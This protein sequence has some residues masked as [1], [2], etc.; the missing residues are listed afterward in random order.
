MKRGPIR[1]FT[2]GTAGTRMSRGRT[3]TW[4]ATSMTFTWSSGV[5]A[6]DPAAQEIGW[7]GAGD[8]NGFFDLE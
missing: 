5:Y 8:D 4:I 2:S 3:D 6:G 1:R 7:F